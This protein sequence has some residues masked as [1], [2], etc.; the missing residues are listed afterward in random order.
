MIWCQLLFFRVRFHSIQAS[1]DVWT[2]PPDLFGSIVVSRLQVGYGIW[3]NVGCTILL[4]VGMIYLPQNHLH[5]SKSNQVSP[6]LWYVRWVQ[7]WLVS[8][9]LLSSFHWYG[10]WIQLQPIT[11]TTQTVHYH[12]HTCKTYAY[13][14]FQSHK[15]DRQWHYSSSIAFHSYS[16]TGI[17]SSGLSQWLG[18]KV[19]WLCV[20]PDRTKSW[21]W[22]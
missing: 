11:Y 6:L 17:R 7:A 2:Q 8:L 19:P 10:W 20:P 14:P 3:K 18:S 22:T 15:Q 21:K 13:Q 4:S 9:C 1:S 16:S 12:C 5:I